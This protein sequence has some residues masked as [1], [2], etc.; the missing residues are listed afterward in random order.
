[1]FGEVWAV[2][3]GH[4]QMANFLTSH[5]IRASSQGFYCRIFDL[6]VRTA[7]THASLHKRV[8][9]GGNIFPLIFL[10]FMSVLL[11]LFCS[12]FSVWVT[13]DFFLFL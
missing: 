7:R 3:I 1:M 2:Y 4:V 11:S 10:C 5:D 13:V 9:K 6:Y 8:Q 12:G